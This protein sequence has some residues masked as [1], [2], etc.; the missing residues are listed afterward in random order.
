M[1][2]LLHE[3]DIVFDQSELS[4]GVVQLKYDWITFRK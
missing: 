3:E 4:L 2:S 1:Q